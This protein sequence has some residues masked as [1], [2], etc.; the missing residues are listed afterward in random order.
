MNCTRC[1]EEI[2]DFKITVTLSIKTDR[3]AESGAWE[4]I[5]NMENRANDVLCK[6]CFDKFVDALDKSMNEKIHV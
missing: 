5:A 2:N 3:K 1:E 6:S 4:P